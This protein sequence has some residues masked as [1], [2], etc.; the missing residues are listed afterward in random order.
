[1]KQTIFF[2]SCFWLLL[3]D[4]TSSRAQDQFSLPLELGQGIVFISGVDPYTFSAQLHPSLGFGGDPKK[5]ILGASAAGVY[6]N[7]DWAFMWGGRLSLH[8]AKLRKQ[9][10][11]IGPRISYGSLQFVGTVLMEHADL[12]RVA[13]GV[14]IDIWDGSLLISPKIGY[15]KKQERPF[16]EVALGMNLIS[17]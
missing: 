16:W 2:I 1:M 17:K 13:G 9:P 7:P 12:R 5:I 3:A 6:T 10:I 8:L 15:D 4:A 11:T 14:V